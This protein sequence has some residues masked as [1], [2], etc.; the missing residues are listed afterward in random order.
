M[1]T[2][3]F[4]QG[5]GA[6]GPGFDDWSQLVGLLRETT[7]FNG[8]ETRPPTLQLLPP[9]ERRR[10]GMLVKLALT[11]GAQAVAHA[12]SDAAQ[13]P[14]VFSASGGDGENCHVLCETLASTD[15][16]ISP[17]RFHNSVHNAASG[18]WSIAT[19][20]MASSTSL[21]AHDAGFA[22]GL[23]E[24]VTQVQATQQDCMLIACDDHY[25]GA[26]G[27]AR[28]IADRMAIALVLTPTRNEHSLAELTVD[29]SGQP[30]D[31]QAPLSALQTIY[32]GIPTARG[33]NLMSRLARNEPGVVYLDYLSPLS[34]SVQVTPLRIS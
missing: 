17:T 14:T 26:L 28:P 7:P 20:S 5:I 33:L 4:L 2:R 21:C 30:A 8:E 9:A 12:G 1:S 3:V 22:A 23:L 18:Y 34:L 6:I 16:S 31:E 15:R 10:V 11:S 19:G 24:A 29:L 32:K 27:K 13:L 25:G